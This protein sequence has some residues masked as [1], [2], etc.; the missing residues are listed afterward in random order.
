MIG[1]D[2]YTVLAPYAATALG[3][4]GLLQRV[5]GRTQTAVD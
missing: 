1:C 4:K 5:E 2:D 3:V